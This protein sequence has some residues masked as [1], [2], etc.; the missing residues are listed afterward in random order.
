MLVL[1]I[2]PSFWASKLLRAFP[3]S[4][5]A[6]WSATFLRFVKGRVVVVDPVS[7]WLVVSLPPRR[8]WDNSVFSKT[9][10]SGVWFLKL[11]SDLS[12]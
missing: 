11:S 2:V 12:Q 7:G 8:E 9:V 10:F 3:T 4:P 5:S 1:V 6:F